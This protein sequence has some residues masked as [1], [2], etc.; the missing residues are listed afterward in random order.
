MKILCLHGKGANGQIFNSQTVFIRQKLEELSPG[1]SFTFDFIDGPLPLSPSPDR[2]LVSEPPHYAFYEGTG[3]STIRTAHAW[4]RDVL[5]LRGPYDGVLAFSQGCALVSSYILYQQWYEPE[6]L[7]PFKFAIFI[8]GEVPI[9]ALKDLGCPVSRDLEELDLRIQE[10]SSE[11]TTG[12][13]HENHVDGGGETRWR[14]KGTDY[15][16]Y[17]RRAQFDSDDC[18]GLNLN[19]IP[20]ELKI[21]IPTVHVF[22]EGDPMVAGSVRLAGLCDP[23][24]RKVYNH[25]GGHEI[26]ETEQANHDLAGMLMW[27]A[28]RGRWPGQGVD[29]E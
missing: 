4:L 24:I 9:S 28:D 25:G 13:C 21:R 7:P 2:P 26:P 3:V 11:K 14:S 20:L 17:I 10:Q 18:F 12:Q 27:C 5:E 8:C 1:R 6:A 22:G 19:R 15:A 29:R 23:Y 16:A